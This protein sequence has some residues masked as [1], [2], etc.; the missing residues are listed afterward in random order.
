MGNACCVAARDKMVVPNSSAG[1]N[2]QR[3]NIRH[4]PSWSFRWDNRGRVAGEETSLS[5]LSDGIS[6]NDGSEIKFESAFVSSEGSPL[7]SFRTQT[8]QKS[9]ASDLSFPRNSSMNTVFEQK[10]NVSTES[11]APS[12]LSPAQLSLSLASQPSSFPTSPL[13]SQSYLHPAS[14][15]TLKLT[16]HPRLSKQVSDGQIYGQNSLS[17]SSATEERQGTP[18]RYDSSQSGPSEGWS[19]Q[20][21]SEM[22]SSSR[23]NK[24]L[25][26]DNYDNDCFG[27]QRDKIDHHGNRM[28]KHQQHTCGA[29]SR[30]L[31][32]KSL[33]SSQKIFMT[34]ELSVSAILACGHVYHGECL[35][36]MTLEIDKFDPS[37]PICTMGEKNTAKLSEKALKVEMDLKARHNKRLRN[38]V[39]D[40]DFDCDDFVMFDHSHRT[41]AAASKSPRL[42]SSSSAKSYSAKPFLARHFSFGSRSNYKSPKENLPVKKKGFFWTK[43]SKI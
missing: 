8:L 24:A 28:S 10:E 25:S 16:Q 12:Y 41:A 43:S 42:V 39:L 32:E 33:W 18:T 37:C 14:S 6:R 2:L 35:E 36:Q 4:S 30:P 19:L 22:M 1:E 15:S 17:R 9:P 5:W 31:S 38:R 11:A 13:S 29:C 20:A 23:S 3:S 21:F 26:Y 27:L 7:D 34:N 40:S